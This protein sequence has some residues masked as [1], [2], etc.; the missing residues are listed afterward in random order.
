MPRK[1]EFSMCDLGAAGR[2]GFFKL[3]LPV[4]ASWYLVGLSRSIASNIALPAK[5]DLT[6]MST[7]KKWSIDT[8]D[9]GKILF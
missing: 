5:S 9:D 3:K 8:L 2:A 4:S 6:I 7:S 1:T